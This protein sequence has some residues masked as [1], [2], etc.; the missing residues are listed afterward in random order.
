MSDEF[1]EL[2]D[3][4]DAPLQH[5]LYQDSKDEMVSHGYTRAQ[6]IELRSGGFPKPIGVPWAHWFSPIELSPRQELVIY[7]AANGWGPKRIAEEIGITK[8]RVGA[9]LKTPGVRDLVAL[10]QQEIYGNQPKERLR[11]MTNKALDTLDEILNNEQE[12]SQ[13]KADVAKYVVDQGVG[14]P[15]QT[16]EV[17]G[18]LLSELIMRLDN[19]KSREVVQETEKLAKPPDALETFVETHIPTDVKVGDR[20][21]KDS[22]E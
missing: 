18:N 11:N 7:L 16:H 8:E 21:K 6:L 4:S 13:L 22:G 20:G 10:K 15:T 3:D 17:K 19:D 2:E 14:K 9:I 12:K 1:E 5:E